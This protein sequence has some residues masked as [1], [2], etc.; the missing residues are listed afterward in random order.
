VT[1]ARA[2]KAFL[3]EREESGATNAVRKNRYVLKGMVEFSEA[4]GY[5]LPEQWTALDV[6]E[7]RSAWGVAPNTAAKY[8]EI[9]RA[10]F[11]FARVNKWIGESPA[12]DVRNPKGKAAGNTRERMPFTD[13][14]LRRMY[15]A[16]ETQYGKTPIRWSRDVHHRPARGET[17]NYRYKW[18]GQDLS[19]F[20][21]ISVYTGLRISDVALGRADVPPHSA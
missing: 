13:E 14:E 5:T 8:L 16:C 15:A 17:D 19:D 9:V 11:E 21:S 3:F 12:K 18:T 1:I 4:K 2:I 10:F 7:F 6:R 20:I